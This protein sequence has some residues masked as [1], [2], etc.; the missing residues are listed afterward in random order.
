VRLAA[1]LAA[2]ADDRPIILHT[3]TLESYL[4]DLQRL[5][6]L[7]NRRLEEGNAEIGTELRRMI[8]RVTVIPAAAGSK[9]IVRV[10]GY[11]E[12]LLEPS[13]TRMFPSRSL[14]AGRVVAEEGLESPRRLKFSFEAMTA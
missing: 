3:A 12:S 9:P 10:S 1:E 5:D 8:E 6:E 4:T 14:S 7:L 11:L 2:L 13:A